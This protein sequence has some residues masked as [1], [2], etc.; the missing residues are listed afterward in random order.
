MKEKKEKTTII[1]YNEFGRETGWN[2][3]FP[4]PTID[5][6]QNHGVVEIM[7]GCPNKCRFCHAGVYYRPK[8][9]K[10]WNLIIKE[11]DTLVYGAGYKDIT[12]SSL[13]SGDYTNISNLIDLLNERYS[14]ENV[15]ISLPSLRVNSLSLDLIEKLGE[16]KKSGFNLC[17]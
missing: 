2:S 13:S 6:V 9:E 11:I 10:D 14:Q 16:V 8:R 1:K 4:V 5:V 12:L 17:R 3:A 7:R 15:S